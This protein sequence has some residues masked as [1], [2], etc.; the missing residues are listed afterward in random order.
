M[1]SAERK[2]RSFG[3]SKRGIVHRASLILFLIYCKKL[4]TL[5]ALGCWSLANPND[6]EV[7]G[8]SPSWP[9]WTGH[10]RNL[11]DSNPYNIINHLIA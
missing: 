7:E 6:S 2:P 11:S 5:I 9:G 1:G 8:A 4:P 10:P 3:K